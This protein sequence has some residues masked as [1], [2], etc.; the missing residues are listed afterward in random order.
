MIPSAK[1]QWSRTFFFRTMFFACV[2]KCAASKSERATKPPPEIA[3]GAFLPIYM[4]GRNSP[5]QELGLLYSR[6]VR[7]Y[8]R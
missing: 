4:R 2:G 6:G 1:K 3:P 5:T 8:V 7:I